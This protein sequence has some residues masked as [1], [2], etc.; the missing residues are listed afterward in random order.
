M[1]PLGP[2]YKGA[3]APLGPWSPKSGAT[4]ANKLENL[5][6]IRILAFLGSK[7]GSTNWDSGNGT[8]T[9]RSGPDF[10]A[11]PREKCPNQLDGDPFGDKKV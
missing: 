10:C 5:P 4:D 7:I 1:G 9:A 11:F 3:W 2:R 6:E 8:P